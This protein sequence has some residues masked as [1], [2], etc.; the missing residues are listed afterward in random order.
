MGGD[1]P[2]PGPL[3][4]LSPEAVEAP[5]PAPLRPFCLEEPDTP[6]LFPSF[7]VKGA[8]PSPDP[9]LGR[10]GSEWTHLQ[11]RSVL[12]L[13]LATSGRGPRGRRQAESP[14]GSRGLEGQKSSGFADL[15]P[16]R[17]S[18]TLFLLQSQSL[19]PREKSL[20]FPIGGFLTLFDV[21]GSRGPRPC[22][23]FPSANRSC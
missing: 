10:V 18:T 14:P 21:K 2:G 9:D 15:F 17:S 20:E 5:P 11:G 8:D 6:L 19:F 16:R 4:V 3:S 12:L 23:I 7:P 13:R 1:S 22:R